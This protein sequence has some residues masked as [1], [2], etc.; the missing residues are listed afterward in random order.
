YDLNG[1]T[2]E[3][4]TYLL[5]QIVTSIESSNLRLNPGCLNCGSTEQIQIVCTEGRPSRVCANCISKAIQKAQ[6]LQIEINRGRIS[7]TF[8]LP[9]VCALVA[10]V[11]LILW[12]GL[13]FFLEFYRVNQNRIEIDHYTIFFILCVIG[14]VGYFS[15]MCIGVTL[16]KSRL[17]SKAPV[18]MSIF[19][20]LISCLTGEIAH[21]ALNFLGKIGVFEI[22]LAAQML[23]AIVM[24]YSGLHLLFKLVL[25]GFAG[26]ACIIW[27]SSKEIIELKI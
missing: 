1:A 17:L 26:G 11:W 6:R 4:I 16:Q 20:V 25:V 18:T 2:T 21:I 24:R 8:T 15:G 27:A 19:L 3:A 23:G 22:K 13:D 10:S 7:T 14:V 12:M 5:Q 9:G